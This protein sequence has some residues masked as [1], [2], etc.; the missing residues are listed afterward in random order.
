MKKG[1][2]L[3]N[4]YAVSEVIGAT[5]LVLIA[6]VAAAS[7]Y[8]Q[9]LDDPI[10]RTEPNVELMGYVSENG[11]VFIEHMGG[12]V[13]D[14]NIKGEDFYTEIKDLGILKKI[15]KKAE[16]GFFDIYDA[17]YKLVFLCIKGLRFIHNGVLPTYLVWTLLGIM[18]LF[19]IF[20]K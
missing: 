18:G 11:D 20:L 13:L 6:V 17:C 8:S 12:E 4:S 7:I 2:I 5:I 16:E 14:D 9:I 3:A 1:N 15:Y 19:F 10:P